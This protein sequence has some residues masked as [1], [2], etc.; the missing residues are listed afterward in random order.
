VSKKGG[1]EMAGVGIRRN[2]FTEEQVEILRKNPYVRTVCENA[3]SFTDDFKK[4]FM[5]LYREELMTPFDILSQLGI[6]YYI[7]GSSRVQGLTNNLKREYK[8]QGSI[9]EMQK[10]KPQEKKYSEVSP[11]Q[12]IKRLRLEVEYLR[13]EQEFL[14][15][16]ILAAREEKSK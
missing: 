7:L 5:R 6:D 1:I 8:R 16:I 13:Q 3:V 14:K 12:E 10:E 15:K 4:E 11:N 9:P 2:K